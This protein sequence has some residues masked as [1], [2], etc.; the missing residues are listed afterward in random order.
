M[1]GLGLG[2]NRLSSVLSSVA[3]IIQAGLQSWLDFTKSE[4]TGSELVVNGDFSA[5]S[6]WEEGVGWDIN[7][8]ENRVDCDG[9]QTSASA[10]TTSNGLNVQ[11]LYV[12]FSFEIS[13]Y[14]AGTLSATIQGTGGV[15]FSNISGDEVYSINITSNDTA[16]DLIFTASSDFIGSISNVTIK[17]V[18]QFVKD[19]SPNTNNA[20]LFT[21]KAMSLDG[22]NDEVEFQSTNIDSVTKKTVAIWINSVVD[23]KRTVLG[24][25]DTDEQNI[26]IEASSN[27]IIIEK[28]SNNEI[29]FNFSSLSEDVW[30]R[31]VVTRDNNDL[32]KAYINGVKSINEV[33]ETEPLL[34]FTQL[35]MKDNEYGEFQ[36]LVS[37][38]QIW[39]KV[40][41]QP[42]VTFDYNNPN[43]LVTDSANTGS[44][45]ALSNLKGYWALSEGAGSVAYDSSGQGNN[46]TIAGAT[47]VD[48]QPT[49]PQLGMMDWAKGSNLVNYSEDFSQ[50]TL[51]NCSIQSGFNAPNGNTD[52]YK[53]IE[54][55]TSVLKL[56]RAVNSTSTTANTSYSASIYVKA[57]ERTKVRVWAYHASNQ[58]FYVDY[59]LTDNSYLGSGGSNSQVDGYS[60]QNIGTD[61][62]KRITIIGQKNA[63]YHWDVAVA[64][65]DA[66]GNDT[67]LG[68]GTSGL[69]I[70]GAQLE[71]GSSAGNYILTDG[72]AAIDVTTIQNPTNKG[73]DILGNP[74]RLRENAFNLDGSGYAE[75]ADDN[76]LDMNEGFSVSF[77]RKLDVSTDGVRSAV[78]TKGVG[79]GSGTDKGLAFT[80][81]TNKLY[82]DINADARVSINKLLTID[83]SWVFVT[84]TY[85][86]NEKVRL[87]VDTDDAI[88]STTNIVGLINDTHPIIV[89]ADKDLAFKDSALID[90]V[91]WYNRALTA[92]EITNNYKVGLT[93]HS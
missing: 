53:L 37:D 67:Y 48:D 55:S 30:Y 90:E 7:T 23:T 43:K 72:A 39:D 35:G 31:L 5:D 82:V 14:S 40:W 61:G 2:L 4:V 60:I 32:H 74:L 93:A 70:F 8:V 33:T 12:L 87:Y 18:T 86:K 58:Y 25:H 75:V 77:W 57:G 13:N 19:K 26:Q 65:L 56:F 76:S 50:A 62:W 34:N 36:G 44:S 9:T 80:M 54:D 83:G 45:I 38:L 46:G 59:D 63:I 21:G 15:E 29:E 28:S 68:D 52:A 73:Y 64:P 27:K 6:D 71:E 16:P 1:L 91:I 85:T 89:G 47:Y 11:G 88:V 79:L 17:E 69:Y 78:L 10:L 42:D 3:S 41:T 51:S 20:K 66:S 22:A 81:L 84:A 92:T 24:R 49:I